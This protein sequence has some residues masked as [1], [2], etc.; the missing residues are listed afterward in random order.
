MKPNPGLLVSIALSLA[1]AC[2]Q[3]AKTAPTDEFS[4]LSGLDEKSDA[5]SY[6]MKTL[7]TLAYGD[8]SASKAYSKTPRYRAYKFDGTAG[9]KVDVWVRSE[10][11]DAVAWLLDKSYHVL[12]SNDDG[13]DST[14][15]SHL[16]ATLPDSTSTTHWIVYREYNRSSAHFTVEL[17]GGPAWSSSCQT[18]AD[19]VAVSRGGC[20][21]NGVNVAVA[22]GAEADYADA[23]ACAV[24]PHPVCPFAVIRDTRVAQCNF[25]TN[26]CEMIAPEDISCGGFIANAHHCPSDYTCQLT[27]N[28][29]DTPGKCVA[30]S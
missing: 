5:F 15:D 6:Q 24:T 3:D 25:T 13:D 29:P 1:P 23:N 9:D 14:L 8:T 12:A 17:G 26:H 20:C 19:C 27:V 22:V 4:A 16:V 2:A 21:P 30:G 18:D 10:D 7:G 28:H 11:G